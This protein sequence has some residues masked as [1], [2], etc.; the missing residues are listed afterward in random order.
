MAFPFWALS[1]KPRLAEIKAISL[2]PNASRGFCDN[3]GT[4]LTF[5]HFKSME[6]IEI[7]M[8]SL[9][10]ESLSR[11]SMKQILEGARRHWCWL[12]ENVGWWDIP[13]DGWKRFEE[14]SSSN[15]VD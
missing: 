4:T 2:T 7:A 10:E 15:V 12:K 8:G 1:F 5:R 13:S 14:G 11:L 3:C 6:D 9:D